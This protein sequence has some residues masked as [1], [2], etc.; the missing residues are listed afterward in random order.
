MHF[1][2]SCLMISTF[3]LCCLTTKGSKRT[4]EQ[5]ERGNG[6]ERMSPEKEE[7]LTWANKFPFPTCGKYSKPL[8][9]FR[10]HWERCF[11]WHYF[12]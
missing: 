8:L 5:E 2:S 10:H 9:S 11:V 7:I 4:K 6:K 1:L 3:V 12:R